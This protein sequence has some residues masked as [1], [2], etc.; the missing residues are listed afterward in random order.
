MF[1]ANQSLF[2]VNNKNF[3]NAIGSDWSL[4]VLL[5]F[6]LRLLGWPTI[7]DFYFTRDKW[8]E[9][10]CAVVTEIVIKLIIIRQIFS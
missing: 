8:K 6:R 7:C 1:G 9:Y 5:V 2:T 10:Q 4:H 3:S